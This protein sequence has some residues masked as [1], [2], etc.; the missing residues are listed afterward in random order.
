MNLEEKYMP[1]RAHTHTNLNIHYILHIVP[2]TLIVKWKFNSPNNVAAC[3]AGDPSLTAAEPQPQVQR[4]GGQQKV[5]ID[6]YDFTVLRPSSIIHH[7]SSII[8][9]QSSII[10][11]SPSIKVWIT[12]ASSKARVTSELWR[13]W[14][15]TKQPNN[16]ANIEASRFSNQLLDWGFCQIWRS[17]IC[18]LRQFFDLW[19]WSMLK[20][21][22]NKN[23]QKAKNPLKVCV[24][25]NGIGFARTPPS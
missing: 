8:H 17:V 14:H 10:H 9:H 24:F 22:T 19:T 20:E 18:G 12:W 2:F 23:Q 6:I 5:N 15:T 11:H 16:H 4:R 21:V 7:P 25:R 1:L 13:P 3:A